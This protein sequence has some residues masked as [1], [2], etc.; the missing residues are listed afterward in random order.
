M[1]NRK[2][3]KKE[4]GKTKKIEDSDSKGSKGISVKKEDNFSEWYVDVVQK[5]E[6]ADYA[7][8]KGFMVI[9]PN[10]YSIWQNLQDYFNKV[11]KGMGV[12]NA[13]FP[14][15]IPDSFFKR[16]A[17]HAEGFAPELAYVKNTEEGELLAIRHT[18][19]TIMYDSY[20]RWIRSWR[21]LPLKINQWC[22]V[23]RWEV[24]QTKPFLRTREFLWQE[25]HC[26]FEDKEG[27]DENMVDMI[28]EYKKMVEDLLAIPTFVGKKSKAE[29]FPGADT[30]MTLEALMPD[31]KCLQCGTSHN[32]GQNFAKSFNVSFKGKDEKDNYAWQTSWG[33]ST[34]LIG[35]I[36]MVH[37]DDRGLV[38][39]PKIAERKAVIVPILFD[40]S[41]EKVLKKCKEIEGELKKFNVILDDREGYSSG[42]KFNE[43]EMKGIPIRIEI[44][45]RDVEKKQVVI[46]RRDNGKK[47]IVSDKEIVKKVNSIL[48]EIQRDLFEKAKKFL[49]SRFDEAKTMNELKKK[50]DERKIVKVFM[51]DDP[52]VEAEIKSATG[53]ATSRIIEESKKEGVCVFSGKKTNVIAY[54][55]KAY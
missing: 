13:Y 23:V 32:L 40:D 14:L 17:K 5:A 8:I 50:I 52:L 34:R 53:G 4:V 19:E 41:K 27:A 30:T 35:A 10:A 44:G 25:G 48:D 54:F 1:V 18:S 43:W 38:I 45:P 31:G 20:S 16:E 33:F 12:Q 49:D 6:L 26:V 42:Y 11:L 22:N 55:A 47:E 7:P 37:G 39:P 9:R 21:D 24:K 29:K 46:V 3:I 28:G 36:T 51:V 2:E 15:L